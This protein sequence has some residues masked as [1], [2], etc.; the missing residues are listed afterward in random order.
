MQPTLAQP[1]PN[2]PIRVI[3]PA[4]AGGALDIAFRLVQPQLSRILGVPLVITNR[5]GGSGI[6][7]MEAVATAKPDGYT[8]AATST[9]TITVVNVSAQRVP[10][11]LDAFIPIGNYA[12]YF[13]VLAI[14]AGAPWQNFDELKTYAKQ[15][16]GKLSYGSV[17]TLSTLNMESIKEA[18]GLDILQIPYPGA[19]QAIIAVIGEQLDIAAVP[20]SGGTATPR[21]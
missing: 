10:Y 16:P 4:P 12:F 18:F 2:R 5:V 21:S 11:K 19:P 14:R 7:G 17:G 6:I 3:N 13:T 15:Y 9:S 20:L 8:L 1:Y